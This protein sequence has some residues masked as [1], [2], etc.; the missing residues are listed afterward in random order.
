M[1][2]NLNLFLILALL[3]S[4]NIIVCSSI[5]INKMD[6][7][8]NPQIVNLQ[9]LINNHSFIQN[10]TNISLS[11]LS[12]QNNSRQSM[13][14]RFVK[15]LNAKND[16]ILSTQFKKSIQSNYKIPGQIFKLNLHYLI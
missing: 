16:F 9:D 8:T 5:A 14:I 2:K 6:S 4:A 13:N 1:K 15:S 3:F 7:S 11:Y 10:N 12:N